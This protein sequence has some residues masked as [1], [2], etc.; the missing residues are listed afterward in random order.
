M[1]IHKL[2]LAAIALLGVVA[3]GLGAVVLARQAPGERPA[4]GQPALVSTPVKAAPQPTV[5]S[6]HG[7]TFLVPEMIV[8]IQPPFD[9]RIDKVLVDLGSVV[10]VG[11]PLVE[12]FSTEI[13]SAKSE[14]EMAYSQWK[15]DKQ[16]YDYKTR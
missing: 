8:R 13:A 3:L 6:L 5:L 1:L 2:R 14:Y 12:L 16:V 15:H 4:D 11:D 10:K 9:C 7:T